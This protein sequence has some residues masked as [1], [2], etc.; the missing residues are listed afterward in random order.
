MTKVM[1]ETW[2][3]NLIDYVRYGLSE[4]AITLASVS[5]KNGL[6]SQNFIKKLAKKFKFN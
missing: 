1:G 2:D 5:A 3:E 4:S 6:F